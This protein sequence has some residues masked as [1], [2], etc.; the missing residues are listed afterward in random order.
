[1]R[2]LF[3]RCGYGRAGS[4]LLS[5]A[6]LISLAGGCASMKC[7]Q[8]DPSPTATS[9][10]PPEAVKE[11]CNGS[12]PASPVSHSPSTVSVTGSEPAP[13]GSVVS[14]EEIPQT[15]SQ[16]VLPPAPPVTAESTA[17]Q[18]LNSQQGEIIRNPNGNPDASSVSPAGYQEPTPASP[19]IQESP[20]PNG[21]SGMTQASQNDGLFQNVSQESRS[22]RSRIQF[23][24]VIEE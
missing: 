15:V 23:R 18:Y 11:D 21:Y 10:C 16:D 7:G 20:I 13:D 8:K 2:K 22:G 9:P 17:N 14:G 24:T 4:V 1:M 3:C 12:C 19:Q 5:L 6:V